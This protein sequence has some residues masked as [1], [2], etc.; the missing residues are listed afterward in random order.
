M[1]GG[2]SPIL[3]PGSLN[4]SLLSLQNKNYKAVCLELKPELIRVRS[5]FEAIPAARPE[6]HGEVTWSQGSFTVPGGQDLSQM[7]ADTLRERQALCSHR[8]KQ[9]PK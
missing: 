8:T 7:L 2:S 6:I 4:P 5:F 1:G 3:R 9:I